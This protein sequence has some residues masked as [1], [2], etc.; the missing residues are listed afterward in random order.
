MVVRLMVASGRSEGKPIEITTPRFII[1]RG[2]DCNLRPN[3]PMVSRVHAVI[4]VRDD[5]E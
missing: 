4:E 2:P 1:G 3:N 5:R